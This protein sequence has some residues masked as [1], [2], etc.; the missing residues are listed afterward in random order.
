MKFF[1]F[2]LFVFLAGCTDKN[3]PFP[4]PASVEVPKT[5]APIPAPKPIDTTTLI[6]AIVKKSECASYKWKQ[7]GFAPI[8]YVK[9]VAHSYAKSYCEFNSPVVKTI[10]QDLGKMDKDALAYYGINASNPKLRLKQVYTFITGLGMRES[11]GNYGEGRDKTAGYQTAYEAETGA[12]Q[13]SA[14]SLNASLSLKQVYAHFQSNPE[15]CDLKTFTEGARSPNVEF[16][17]TG[18]GFEFQRFMRICPAAQAQYTA[19]GIRVLRKHWGPINRK[20]AEYNKS[21][22]SMFSEIEKVLSCP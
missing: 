8:G 10:T 18:P 16:I 20:E 12:W 7:R 21:C 5:P 9:G 19:V 15:N 11:S 17:G 6:D 13:F 14:N 22:E 2:I 3:E 1:A 4:P